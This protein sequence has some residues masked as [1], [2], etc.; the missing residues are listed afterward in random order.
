MASLLSLDE[1]MLNKFSN[2]LFEFLRAENILY[3]SSNSSISFFFEKQGKKI[4]KEILNAFWEYF[5]YNEEE[6]KEFLIQIAYAFKNNV[7]ISK[8]SFD[9]II[10][11]F[12]TANNNT[13]SYLFDLL[14]GLY[15]NYK[16]GKLAIKKA[17]EQSLKQKFDF[18][19]FYFGSVNGIIKLEKPKL[20]RLINEFNIDSKKV[21]P[22]GRA[23]ENHYLDKI[24]MLCFRFNI[25]TAQ[26]EFQ[27]FKLLHPYYE[28]VIDMEGFDYTKFEPEWVLSHRIMP[29]YKKMAKSKKLRSALLSYIRNNYHAGIEQVLIKIT[30]FNVS[31]V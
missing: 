9:S 3:S 12:K 17:L 8:T 24:L 13:K 30:Y 6:N 11:R 7:E 16:K 20:M 21:F 18:D 23:Y 15:F 28:W 14:T 31:S 26:Q 2:Y 10:N 27:K 4:D 29:Y 1:T 25:D 22:F 19:I 5:V